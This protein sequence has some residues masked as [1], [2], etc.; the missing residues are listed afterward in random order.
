MNSFQESSA[1]KKGYLF[2]L[3]AA[4]IW[5]GFILVSRLGGI[6][7][8]TPY[9]VIAVR[10]LTCCLILLPFWLFKF[11]F[12][13]MSIRNVTVSLIGGLAYALCAFNGFK[14]APASH[15]AVLLPGLMPLIIIILSYFINGE[16][17]QTSKWFGIC[18]IT[19]GI[20]ILFWQE[21]QQNATLNSGHVLLVCAAFFWALFSVLVKR[22]E[23][24]PW[25]ATI[26]LAIITSVFYFPLYIFALPKNISMSSWPTLWEDILLQAFYQGVLA[27][28]IQMLFYVK[29]VQSIGPSSMGT[30]M[31]VV[32]ILAGFSAIVVFNEPLKVELVLSLLLVSAGAWVAHSKL[33]QSQQPAL[34]REN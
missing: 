18:I 11:R 15:A 27:T 20:S 32:P 1:L 34:I 13:I 6:S 23:I 2:A 25:E 33:F 19:L 28:I 22:W 5:S 26:C 17:H 21:F 16:K 12:Q 14:V 4:F 29:A 7:D 30:V 10:Y 31:A 3:L 8:L 24:S 9:D